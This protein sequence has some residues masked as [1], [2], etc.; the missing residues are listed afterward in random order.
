MKKE[1]MKEIL[2]TLSCLVPRFEIKTVP[3][4]MADYGVKKGDTFVWYQGDMRRMP[5]GGG[6]GVRCSYLKFIDYC[7]CEFKHTST[8]MIITVVESGIN[9]TPEE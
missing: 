9:L 5:R 4:W 8:G 7:L 6:Y 1:E 2:H 3:K